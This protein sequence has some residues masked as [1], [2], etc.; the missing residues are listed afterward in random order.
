MSLIRE[1]KKNGIRS[2]GVV[3]KNKLMGCCLKEAIDLKKESRGAMDS[4]VSKEKDICVVRWFNNSAVTLAFSFVDVEPID[5]V[6]QWSAT[7]KEYLMFAVSHVCKSTM[8]LWAEW[9]NLT[10]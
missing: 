10:V 5:H 3:K 4:K 2:L 1:L 9:T 8:N 6:R 7:E